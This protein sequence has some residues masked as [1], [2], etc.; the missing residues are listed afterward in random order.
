[1]V[2]HRVI[3]YIRIDFNQSL[4]LTELSIFDEMGQLLYVEQGE[5]FKEPYE[6]D[7]KEQQLSVTLKGDDGQRKKANQ[8][9]CEGA[10]INVVHRDLS[11]IS[12]R[13][14]SFDL[15]LEE[16][17][18][19]EVDEEES[20]KDYH[21]SNHL[22]ALIR[23]VNVP[24]ANERGIEVGGG[25]AKDA[26][27]DVIGYVIWVHLTNNYL[28]NPGLLFVVIVVVFMAYYLLGLS[29]LAVSIIVI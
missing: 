6:L 10:L 14:V 15:V 13:R 23:V 9:D 20:L 8:I 3:G 25:D 17:L 19:D 21:G 11:Y 26:N 27:E 29:I 5:T 16:E 1:M 22:S 4:A 7:C 18:E 24:E 12:Y 28:V 2:H